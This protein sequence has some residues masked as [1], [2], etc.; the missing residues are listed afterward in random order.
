MKSIYER[1]R[2]PD[3]QANGSP[4]LT[5]LR[6][7]RARQVAPDIE[8]MTEP[9]TVRR[10]LRFRPGR[11]TLYVLGGAFLIFALVLLW[12]QAVAPWWQGVNDQWQ[13]GTAR[14]TQIDANV[15]HDGPSHFIAQY[16]KGAIVVIEIP[17]ADTND[18][19]TYTIPG[20]AAD[21]TTPLVLLSVA[22]DV[23][24]G[25][26]DLIVH[27]AGTDFETVLYNTGS[28]FSETEP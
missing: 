2:P 22:R 7:S 26:I 18:T 3:M 16:Y 8:Y 10:R 23:N 5:V 1:P 21:G 28:A 4:K 19:R 9:V 20:I 12:Q 24:T 13:Y 11:R 27:A 15:G 17:Y 25:R 6:T 14:I